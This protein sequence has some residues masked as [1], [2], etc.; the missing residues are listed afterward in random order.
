MRSQWIEHGGKRILYA[1]YTNFSESDFEALR[2]EV[3]EVETE[4]ARQPENSV[5]SLTDIRGSV[6]S[7]EAVDLFK[8]SAVVAKKYIRKQAVVG[9]TG[10]KKIVFDAVVKLSGQNATAFDDLET[11]KDWLVKQD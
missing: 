9:V 10:L 6:A 11:A 3:V 1:D 2:A 5:L 4:I 7:R 8:K